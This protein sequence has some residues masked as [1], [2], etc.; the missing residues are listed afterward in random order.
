VVAQQSRG[1][2]G[3]LER[4]L[5]VSPLLVG[6]VFLGGVGITVRGLTPRWWL[7][8][9][10]AGQGIYAMAALAY[11]IHMDVTLTQFAGHG[12]LFLLSLFG[13]IAA[14]PLPPQNAILARP[15]RLL[16][17]LSKT[18]LIP[19]I[20]VTLGLY[21]VGLVARPDAG[22][23]MFIQSQFGSV[24]IVGMVV[25]FA[26]GAG[27][28]IQNHIPASVLF[29]ALI[30]QGIYAFMA[31]SLLGTDNRV[32]LAGVIVH[33]L[34]LITAG[35]VVLIQTTEYARILKAQQRGA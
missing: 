7:V 29:V 9:S 21:A 20:G 14:I 11:A 3:F 31:V 8:P 5:H 18:L 4:D 35:F 2:R 10:V 1:I 17:T 34:F 24:V 12:G 28:V 22:V 30:P 33:L 26:V 19:I 6:V 23:S 16:I 32:S 13:L 27:V 15:Q 25:W